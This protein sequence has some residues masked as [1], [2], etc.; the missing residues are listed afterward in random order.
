[1]SLQRYINDTRLL[2]RD[3]QGLFVPEQTIISYVNSA[4]DKVA[5][6]TGCVRRLI[7][8]QAPLGILAVPGS[9]VP[10]AFVPGTPSANAFATILNTEKYS[11]DYANQFLTQLYAG[12]RGVMDVVD[13]A[14]S[15]GSFRPALSWMPWEDLQAY[16]R[17]YNVGIQ[18]FPSIWSTYSEGEFGECWL[19]PVPSQ[20]GVAAGEME[21][22]A[23]CWPTPLYTNDD[24]DAIPTPF[25]SAVKYYAAY[26]AH[27]GAQRVG[28]ADRMLGRFN[29]T[30]GVSRVAV[31]RGKTSNFYWNTSP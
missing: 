23:F 24:F 6:H 14:V 28:A 19:W 16:A 18:N 20:T 7:Y 13:V 9:A 12:V 15:W 30:L 26:L 11:Y 17:A 22:D 27:E 1:M 10:G 21:W 3:L 31:D 2:L 29:E 4:R 8:G 5:E 25:R